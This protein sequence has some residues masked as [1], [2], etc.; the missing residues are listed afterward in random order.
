[1]LSQ[2]LAGL[3]LSLGTVH[4]VDRPSTVTCSIGSRACTLNT[5]PVRLWQS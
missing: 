3:L 4:V 5:L 2:R 1:M